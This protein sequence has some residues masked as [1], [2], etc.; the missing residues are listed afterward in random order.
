HSIEALKDELKVHGRCREIA[1]P[2]LDASAVG[3][4]LA[5][6]FPGHEGST[7]LAGLIHQRTEGN[8]LFVVNVADDL[9]RRGTLVHH[10]RRWVIE[11]DSGLVAIAIPEDVRRMIGHELD[12]V[13]PDERR[14]LEAASVS[15]VEFPAA[16]VAAAER[17]GL[18]DVERGCAELSRRGSFLTARDVAVWPDGTFSGRYAFRHALY[19]EAVYGRLAPA[20]RV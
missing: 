10:A 3:E 15:G 6:R 14:I 9:V 2:R 4:Y 12:R 16:A 1:L 20:R 17:L 19:Q 5:H 7:D 8:P 13:S 18:D 11:G